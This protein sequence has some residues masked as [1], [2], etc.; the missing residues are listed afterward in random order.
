[1]AVGGVTAAILDNLLPG[2]KEE[3]GLNAWKSTQNFDKNASQ[4]YDLPYVQDFLNRSRW[5]R[6]VPFLPYHGGEMVDGKERE[7][8]H[9]T[10]HACST[11]L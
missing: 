9:P 7:A 1:M 3:R 10:Y 2:D 8:L 11:E 4:V 6:F 5:V